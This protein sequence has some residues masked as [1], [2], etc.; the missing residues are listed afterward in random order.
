MPA[1]VLP[2]VRPW[3]I[4][5]PKPASPIASPAPRAGPRLLADSPPSAAEA[6]SGRSAA[7]RVHRASFAN[8]RM[9]I[10]SLFGWPR[11]LEHPSVGLLER[12][13]DVDHRKQCEDDGLEASHQHSQAEENRGHDRRYE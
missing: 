12:Q 10:V 1:V 13:V 3:P 6:V 11:S 2:A 5:Q 8:F 9:T 7:A 4:P